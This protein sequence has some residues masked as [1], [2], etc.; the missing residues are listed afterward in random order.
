MSIEEVPLRPVGKQDIHKLEAAL[1]IATLFRPDVLEEIQKAEE[2]LTWV[3]SL[4]V[5]AAALAREK[6]GY[7]V[8][9]IADE[10]GRSEGTIRNHLTGK[11]KAGKLV[12]ETYEKFLRE[13]VKIELPEIVTRV[14]PVETERERKLKEE[15]EKVK[16]ENEKLK[17]ECEELKNK[18]A[19][20]EEAKQKLE[21]KIAKIREIVGS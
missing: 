19:K 17:K 20:L 5:A 11:T 9:Q 1:L 10:L 7:T 15:L 21:E 3:D 14:A 12:R 4:A 13:G 6:A 2:R 18:I 8:P 16:K